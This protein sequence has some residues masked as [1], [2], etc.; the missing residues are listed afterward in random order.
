MYLFLQQNCYIL[1]VIPSNA[2]SQVIVQVCDALRIGD[3]ATAAAIARRDYAFLPNPAAPRSFSRAMITSLFIQDGCI[4]RYSGVQ[5]VFAGTLLLLSRLLPDEIP[6]HRNWKIEKT[7]MA[8]WELCPTIDHIVPVTR[9]GRDE[10]SNYVTTSMVNNSAKAHWTLEELGW[11]LHSPG[12]FAQW[13]GL[14][15]WFQEYLSLHPEHLADKTIKAWYGAA[16]NG[17]KVA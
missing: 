15:G 6:Y 13:D 5:L 10:R 14:L 8:F 17:M 2:K 7:H 1:I 16:K 9:D 4:D 11:T 12:D 3:S